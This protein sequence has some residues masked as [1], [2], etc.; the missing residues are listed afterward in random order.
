M[1]QPKA[2]RINNNRKI[3]FF[4]EPRLESA[5]IALVNYFLFVRL[6]TSVSVSIKHSKC[7]EC[8]F[9]GHRIP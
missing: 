8:S 6:N 1:C 3:L 9:F 7:R 5:L 2:N 4:L